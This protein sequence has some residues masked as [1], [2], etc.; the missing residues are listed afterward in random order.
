MLNLQ[1]QNSRDAALKKKL[2]QQIPFVPRM[3]DTDTKYDL[4]PIIEGDDEGERQTFSSDFMRDG[5]SAS[6]LQVGESGRA[7]RGPALY[8]NETDT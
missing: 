5:S 7:S 4:D 3:T 2:D 8:R 1:V 6:F